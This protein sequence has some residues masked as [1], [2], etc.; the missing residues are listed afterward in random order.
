MNKKDLL[1]IDDP[2]QDLIDMQNQPGVFKPTPFMEKCRSINFLE[3]QLNKLSDG[4]AFEVET[5]QGSGRYELR[6]YWAAD[7]KPVNLKTFY[8]FSRLYDAL[9][10]MIFRQIRIRAL[11]KFFAAK[12]G[13]YYPVD[14][15]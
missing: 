15:Q 3:R 7:G 8:S 6:A 4:V 5:F 11:N 9:M 10:E 2:L 13:S 12:H 14:F 1:V